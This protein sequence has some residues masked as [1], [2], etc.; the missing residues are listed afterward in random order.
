M[1]GPWLVTIIRNGT[2]PPI[3]LIVRPPKPAVTSTSTS[4]GLAGVSARTGRQQLTSPAAINASR[5]SRRFETRDL[6]SRSFIIM[7]SA[8]FIR[9]RRRLPLAAEDLI[10]RGHFEPVRKGLS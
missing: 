7:N 10:E 4:A 5:P 9:M 3:L 1:G 8:E 2:H 6:R